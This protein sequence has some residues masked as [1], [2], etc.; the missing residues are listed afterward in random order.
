MKLSPH[1]DLDELIRSDYAVRHGLRNDPPEYVLKN[2][3]VL[4]QRLER[5]RACLGAPLLVTSGYR[6]PELN[7]AIGGSIT[8]A[9]VGG[10]AADFICPEFG[11]PYQIARAIEANADAIDFDQL[12]F[13]G[14]WVHI[15]FTQLTQSRRE[16][17]TAHFAGGRVRYTSGLS[18]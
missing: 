4:A 9:H 15:G 10:L 3:R 1:F 12:I 17:L 5:V 13:E 2:L 11:N 16:V 18:T 7:R 6:S 14:T 8:S